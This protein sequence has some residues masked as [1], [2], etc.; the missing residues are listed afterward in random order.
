MTLAGSASD[1][2]GVS[3]VLLSIRDQATNRYWN[4]TGFQSAVTNVVATLS[5][6]G[7]ASTGWSYVFDLGSAPPSSQPYVLSVKAID[8]SGQ[9]SSPSTRSFSIRDVIAPVITLIG[10]NPQT[11][12]VNSPYV[13]LG[14]VATDDVEGDVTSQI[15][16]DSSSVDTTT[17]GS[18][19][20]TYRVT[21]GSG[22][23][24]LKTRT[25][26]I[27]DVTPPSITLVGAE[28]GRSIGRR[29][30]RRARCH[31]NRR[32]RRRDRRPNRH[33]RFRRQHGFARRL[34]RDIQR[35]GLGRKR[36][37]RASSRSARRRFGAS[38]DGACW[39]ESAGHCGWWNL[40][41]VRRRRMG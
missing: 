15:V 30:V 9:Q 1:D 41:R 31:R 39:P 14:A 11:I 27:I 22:N 23:P 2:L 12:P 5:A 6:P 33:R 26:K 4:G 40:R 28:P 37:T 8:S 32:R 10:D 38:C 17:I 20:V 19:V 16:I 7:S 35:G 24:S 34:P 3:Q 29:S 13:E 21:D 18:Y 25:V 36:C